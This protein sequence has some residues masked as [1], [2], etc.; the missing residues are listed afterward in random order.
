MPASCFSKQYHIWGH[1]L[2]VLLFLRSHYNGMGENMFRRKNFNET[3][4]EEIK[5]F[6]LLS[7]KLKSL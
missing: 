6:L 4:Y 5:F 1:I 7:K 2:E 3:N